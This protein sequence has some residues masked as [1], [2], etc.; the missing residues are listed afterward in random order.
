MDN[1][2][3]NQPD[4]NNEQWLDEKLGE[5]FPTQEIILDESAI[6]AAG[7]R[8]P[9]KL[10]IEN[11]LVENWDEESS[12]EETTSEPAPF[13]EPVVEEI[14]PAEETETPVP[15]ATGRGRKKKVTEKKRRP[16]MKKGYGLF[17]IPHILS[18]V[19][20]LALIIAIG[21]SLGRTIWVCCAD[22]MA[23]GKEPQEVTITISDNDT[24]DT[25]SEKL[26][27]ANLIR[28]PGLFKFFAEITEKDEKISV[29]TFKLNSQLD[30]NAM[31]NAMGSYAPAREEVEILFPEGYNCAQIFKLLEKNNVCTV[32]ELE[33]Y[34]AEGE[35]DEYWFLEDVPR[36]DKYCLEGYLAPDTYKFYTNDEPERVLEKFLDEFEDRFTDK[37]HEDLAT[38]QQRYA[39]M[40]ASHGYGE[41][42]LSEHPLTLHTALTLASIV[43]KETSSDKECYDIASVLYNRL[44]N[45]GEYPFLDSD[46]TVYYAIGD[47]FGETDEL[48]ASQLDTDSPYN[49]RNHQGLPPGPICN[50]GV[51]ALYSA[52]DPNDTNYHY[53]VY[54]NSIYEHRF[55]ETYNGHLAL[56]EELGL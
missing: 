48:S 17:G 35:L 28:Y 10:N 50:P 37:M 36:G 56:L 12:S 7:L 18:T 23:F 8:H 11:I 47:Y 14:V 45:P 31:I 2:N 9:D 4:A 15:V 52:L 53:F 30:Y 54:D 24:I 51:Y 34:A 44:T 39:E 16:K 29:G 32:E 3:T 27:K 38:M 41:E 26:S 19:I 13:E 43:Q 6:S 25:I 42:Y 5:A 46:A 55:S 1:R 22:L 49:T 40:L 20:W 33:S 21:V